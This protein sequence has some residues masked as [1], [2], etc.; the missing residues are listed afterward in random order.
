MLTR[1]RPV[2]DVVGTQVA[3]WSSTAS[4]R[5]EGRSRAMKLG[6]VLLTAVIFTLTAAV[7]IN[8]KHAGQ[9]GTGAEVQLQA[10]KTELRVQDGLEYRLISGRKST[11][12]VRKKLADSRERSAAH[13]EQATTLGLSSGAKDRLVAMGQLYSRALDEEVRLL[14]LNERQKAFEFDEAELDPAFDQMA[15][16]LQTEQDLMQRQAQS[17]QFF[18]DARCSSPCCCP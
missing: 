14:S 5:G 8:L 10:L 3:R 2:L 9:R 1:A 12:E 16:V 4:Q 11:Q 7:T 15:E 6:V 17:A 18:S 13:L